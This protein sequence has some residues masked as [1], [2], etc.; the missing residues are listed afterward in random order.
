[1]VEPPPL[2]RTL[3][4]SRMKKTGL[5]IDLRTWGG[6][7]L[8]IK[9]FVTS[10]RDGRKGKWLFSLLILFLLGL[11][12]L[13]V[14]NS[15]VGRDFMTAIGDRNR[16]EFFR[17]ALIYIGVFAVSTIVSVM[18][19][20]TEES[21][22][23]VWREWAT[24]RSIM[25]YAN[26]R[27][28]YRLKLKGEIGNPDQRIA[29][30]IRVFSTM[31]LSFMLMVLNGGFT[32]IAFSGVLWTISPRLFLAAVIYASAGTLLTFLFGRPLIRLNY[33]QLDK[34]A[35]LRSSLIH[36]RGNAESIALAR[37]EGH[38]IRASLKNLGD[39]ASNFRRIISINRRVNFFTTGYNW[40]IQVIPALIVAPL[41]FDGHIEFGVITQS[42]IAFTQLLGA[43]SLIITQF[44]SISSYTAVFARLALLR[45][46]GES[47]RKAEI[48][49]NGFSGDRERIAYKNL[50]LRSPH[51][52]RVLIN[53][54]SLEIP[55]GRSWH[56]CIH[57]GRQGGLE[58][59]SYR[60][61]HI[62]GRS[63]LWI[64]VGVSAC[65]LK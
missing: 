8:S 30:D 3:Q 54:L 52:G 23:L 21:L 65:L 25:S 64:E 35:E 27:V 19:R 9:E 28:Y 47:E 62:T 4:A 51:C 11:N 46:A 40:L 2:K 50:T 58:H 49:A 36:L 16:V 31:T 33:D 1:M 39:L 56:G 15:Y 32:A 24:R 7:L 59:L 43:F 63:A 18:C 6:F 12:G 61:C 14:L 41:F 20:Y 13:N 60:K 42:A 55:H 34:E 37:R 17:M 53:K 48:T 5:R 38:L 45:E 44:Q 26:H 22:G 57:D 10:R 29:D